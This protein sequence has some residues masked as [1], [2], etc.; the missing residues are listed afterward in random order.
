MKT[1]LIAIA[2]LSADTYSCDMYLVEHQDGKKEIAYYPKGCE[3]KKV[4]NLHHVVGVCEPEEKRFL[5]HTQR[6]ET[7]VCKKQQAKQEL[8]K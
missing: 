3:Y 6:N 2:L 4:K 1:I 5:N 8:L 7:S